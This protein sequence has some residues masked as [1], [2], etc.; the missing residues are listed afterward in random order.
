[1]RIIFISPVE[2]GLILKPFLYADIVFLGSAH[3]HLS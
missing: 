2:R 3:F 1:M